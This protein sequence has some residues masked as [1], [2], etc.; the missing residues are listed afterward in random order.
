VIRKNRAEA[1]IV[2]LQEMRAHIG[3]ASSQVPWWAQWLFSRQA[4]PPSR[5]IGSVE[6]PDGSGTDNMLVDLAQLDG[7]TD[8]VALRLPRGEVTDKGLFHIK[9]LPN[10][11]YLDLSG[12]QISDAGLAHLA[13]MKA[14]ESLNLR[15]TGIT[16]AGLLQLKAL[17]KLKSLDVT[18]THVTG[19]GVSE[20]QR[21]LPDL[22]VE[23]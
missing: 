17:T 20:L 4:S 11:K 8:L 1:S 21:M 5:R 9:G 12:T 6:W 3:F 13:Q 16:D 19:V 7:L 18:D 10:L 22:H 2:A 15:G 14:M 23:E